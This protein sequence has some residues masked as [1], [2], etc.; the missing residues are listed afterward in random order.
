MTAAGIDQDRIARCLGPEGLSAKTMRAYFASELETGKDRINALCAQ[1]IVKAMQQGE[2]WALCF[3]AKTRMGFKETSRHELT[4]QGGGPIETSDTSARDA[5][6]DRI[7]G[8]RERL[9]GGE[10]T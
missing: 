10:A 4:G 2:A 3:W 5:L 9:R 7:L 6:R 8:V 1:G